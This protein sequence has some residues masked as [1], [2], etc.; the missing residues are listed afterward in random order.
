MNTLLAENVHLNPVCT[1][2]ADALARLVRA[3]AAHFNAYLPAVAALAMADDARSSLQA[4]IDR[5]DDGALLQWHIFDG[6][7]LCGAVRLKDIDLAD[8]SA[9]I[10]YFIG[11]GQQGRGIA[12]AA[13][14]AVL[15]HAFGPL[16]LHRIELLCATGNTA[17]IRLAARLG[18][19]REGVRRQAEV[20]HGQYIDHFLYSMLSH[21]F[22]TARLSA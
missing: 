20:L 10:G 5:R 2:D 15:A 16:G 19:I 12:T 22:H 4:V 13:V 6:H 11:T 21:E 17:S 14:R 3:N 1:A 9:A 7:V 8:R 18:F